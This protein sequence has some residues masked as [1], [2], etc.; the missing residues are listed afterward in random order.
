MVLVTTVSTLIIV[1]FGRDILGLFGSIYV[2]QD[3]YVALNISLLGCYIASFSYAPYILLS[4]S[5]NHQFTIYVYMGQLVMLLIAV[6]VLTIYF[7]II[8]TVIA[9][10][11]SNLAATIVFNV[12][13][14]KKT[15]IKSL[16]FA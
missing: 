2:T 5:G 13:A 16:T 12:I 3:S 10:T 9:T 7:G 8:G 15:N 6:T 1:Y 4:Y 11:L 14:R